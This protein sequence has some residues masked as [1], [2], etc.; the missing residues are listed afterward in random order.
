MYSEDENNRKDSRTH[1]RVLV[2]FLESCEMPNVS[3]LIAL[4]DPTNVVHSISYASLWF[5]YTP[6]TLVIRRHSHLS[7]CVVCSVIDVVPPTKYI[8]EKG[9][10]SH[11]DQQVI[12]HEVSY[13]GT[14]FG[15]ETDFYYIRTFDGFSPL[16]EL[17][18][19]PLN[20]LE[21]SQEKR[22]ILVARGR[23]FWD[24]RGLHM[25]EFI[26]DLHSN[27]PLAVSFPVSFS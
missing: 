18:L 25:K 12:Y 26:D 13:D 2:D 22:N 3:E 15:L 23:K 1:I 21:D 8:D 11:S 14:R 6:S 17:D 27:A 16:A 10:I 19:V 7:E 4:C 5:L 24:L 9:L 20:M